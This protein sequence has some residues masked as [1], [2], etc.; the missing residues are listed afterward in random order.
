MDDQQHTAQGAL[1]PVIY[2]ALATLLSL[3]GGIAVGFL[4]G[5]GTFN[6]LPGHSIQ[7]LNPLH[8]AIAALPGLAG[9]LAGSALWGVL[10]GR[11]AGVADRRRMALAGALG[12]APL[13]VSAGI[14]L[15]ILEPLALRYFGA[16]LPLHRL[17]TIFFVPTAFIVAGVSAWA[18]GLGLRQP[19][20][21]KALLWR[22]GLTAALAFLV[23][24]LVMEA[25]G[26]VVGAPNAAQRAT[27]LTVLLTGCLAAA[28]AGGGALGWLLDKNTFDQPNLRRLT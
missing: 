23:T 21:A 13:A 5:S 11:L 19:A 27:M 25:A 24:N 2:G 1:R 10:M 20:L 14:L 16:V 12:F 22:T 3:V 8:V 17:F 4:A 6:L 9:F 7:N 15:Q 18:L 26:W 28:L